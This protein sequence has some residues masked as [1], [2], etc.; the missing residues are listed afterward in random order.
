VVGEL[1]LKD[2]YVVLRRA[3]LHNK[4]EKPGQWRSVAEV[5]SENLFLDLAGQ[6][7]SYKDANIHERMVM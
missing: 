4:R 7:G 5:A 2:G 1:I 6:F 3:R